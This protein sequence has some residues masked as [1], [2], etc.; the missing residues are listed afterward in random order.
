MVSNSAAFH[1]QAGIVANPQT[2]G[3]GVSV[4]GDLV[5]AASS[6]IYPYSHPTN[7]GSVRFQAANVKLLTGA[8]INATDLGFSRGLLKN[9]PGFGPGGGYGSGGTGGG[10]S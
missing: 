2:P 3:A 5:V 6:W 9:T 8:G 10:P 1:I 4:T 7:G